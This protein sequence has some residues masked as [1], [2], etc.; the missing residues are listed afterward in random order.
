[1]EFKYPLI[2]DG[3]TGTQLQLRGYDGSCAPEVW[4][5]EHPEAVL[6]FQGRYAEAGSN[7]VYAPTFTANPSILAGHGLDDRTEELNKKLVALSKEAT[8]GKCYTAGDLSPSGKFLKPLGDVSFEDLVEMY[9]RQAKALDEAGVD[10]FAI[11]TMN[12]LPDARAAVLAVRS[13]S[14]KPII[15]SFTCEK[16]GRTM[17]GTDVTAALKIMEGMGVDIFGLNCSTGP[18][19]MLPHIKRLSEIA[20]IPLLAKPNAGLPEIEDGKTVYKC[21]PE[22]FVK[23]VEEMA[24]LGV[25]CFGGCC[26]STEE[27]VAALAKKVAELEEGGVVF[28]GPSGSTGGKLPCVS[29]RKVFLLDPDVTIDDVII[30]DEDLEESIDDAN[31]EDAEIMCIEFKS[32]EDV[33]VFAL[34]EYMINKA[35]CIK[36][37]DAEV[38]EAA[39]RAYQGRA[40]YEG[41]LSEDEL[42]PLV[43]KYGLIVR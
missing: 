32:P 2:L 6:E 15:A 4:M 36:C 34:C 13:F 26:G 5:I 7:I 3:A 24:S 17:M 11:E 9:L 14:D 37:D 21:S 23:N 20:E 39:L 43:K 41:A 40:L 27:H 29:G 1:M 33:E 38:L 19:D 8:G 31:E 25:L 12:S 30:C 35:L 18:E 16:K 42:M 22:D 10:L 28:A